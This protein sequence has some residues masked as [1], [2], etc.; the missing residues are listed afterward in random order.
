M[1]GADNLTMDHVVPLARGGKRTR[2]S[3]APACQACDRH[4]KLGTTVE[5]I[6][7]H[8]HTIGD[9]KGY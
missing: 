5:T 8:I 3:V 6:L 7:D 9:E 4:K 1:V 2:G